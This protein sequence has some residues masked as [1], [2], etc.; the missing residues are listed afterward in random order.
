VGGDAGVTHACTHTQTHTHT[1]RA[2]GGIL[3]NLLDNIHRLG[4][5]KTMVL[6]LVRGFCWYKKMNKRV[7]LIMANGFCRSFL[8]LSPSRSCARALSLSIDPSPS[9]DRSLSFPLSRLA[10]H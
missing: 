9:F 7:K 8:S 4:H 1:H 3:I 6:L 2:E 10:T 5:G